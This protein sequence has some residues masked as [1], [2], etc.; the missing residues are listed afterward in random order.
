[1][2][3]NDNDRHRGRRAR[4]VASCTGA[5]LAA[6]PA[7]AI[8]ATPGYDDVVSDPASLANT[9]VD[10]GAL[11]VLGLMLIALGFGLRRAGRASA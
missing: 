4:F 1:M 11:T 2:T 7:S 10:L 3:H 8:G 6:L 9:G 5:A